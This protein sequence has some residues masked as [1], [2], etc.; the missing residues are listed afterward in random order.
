MKTS[1]KALL[2][3]CSV[4]GLGGLAYYL[5]TQRRLNG[6]SLFNPNAVKLDYIS[7]AKYLHIRDK[8]A[9]KFIGKLKNGD[10]VEI[11]GTSFDKTY[12]IKTI[13][14]DQYNNL[15]IQLT[16]EI[17]FTPKGD[18]DYTFKGATIIFK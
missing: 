8:D 4:I 5:I 15:A 11:K 7:K 18:K 3:V 2:I 6:G 16:P 17:N 10:E 1:T 9:P 14:S 12:K 13:W